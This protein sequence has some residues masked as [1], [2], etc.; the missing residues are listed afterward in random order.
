M[1]VPLIGLIL[2]L[3]VLVYAALAY[4]GS[5]QLQSMPTVFQQRNNLLWAVGCVLL[6]LALMLGLVGYLT[7]LDASTIR[8]IRILMGSAGLL[9]LASQLVIRRPSH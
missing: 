6:A 7:H 9:V 2:G 1:L 3:I 4:T 8:L 5:S